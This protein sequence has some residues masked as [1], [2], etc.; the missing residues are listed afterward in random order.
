MKKSYAVLCWNSITGKVDREFLLD[1]REEA[2][3]YRWNLRR[4]KFGPYW[5]REEMDISI[6]ERMYV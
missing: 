5:Q 4:G 1:N 2:Y 3:I 6:V